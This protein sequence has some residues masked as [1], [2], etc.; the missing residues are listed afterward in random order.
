MISWYKEL[1]VGEQA[2]ESREKIISNICEHKFQTG[3][4]VIF[5][6]V[7][8]KDIFDLVPTF[9]LSEDSYKGRDI[10]ILGIAKG[11]EEAKELSRQMIMNVY[12][13]TGG[14]MIREY[15]SEQ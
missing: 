13:Q 3:I 4:Y 15:Y 10:I 1:F 12:E 14:F 6:A 8:G 2:E 7:N 11:K 9:M 5:L